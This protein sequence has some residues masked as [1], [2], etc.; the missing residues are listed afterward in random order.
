MEDTVRQRVKQVLEFKGI[1]LN[2]ISKAMG[3]P[4]SNLNKQ[5]NSTTSISLR[6]VLVILDYAKNIS[7]E[8]LLRGDGEMEKT[9]SPNLEIIES[10]KAENNML[11][12]ENRVLREQL[13][14]GERK[15][16]SGR[17]A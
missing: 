13:G 2:A 12:G 10:L 8:W 4:Q 14:L 9:T 16:S 5:I 1:T 3:Y 7:A 17:S 11:R 15:V 6:T